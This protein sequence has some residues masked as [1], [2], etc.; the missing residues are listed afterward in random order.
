RLRCQGA[1]SHPIMAGCFWVGVLP[2]IG[3]LWWAGPAARVRALIGTTACLGI[4]LLCA[5]STPIAGVLVVALAAAV[6]P[7][8][9]HMRKIRW[10]ILLGIIGLE[11]V[12]KA[13]VYHLIARID[14]VDGSTGYHRYRLIDAAVHR[15]G[16]WAFMGTRSTAHWGWGLADVTNEYILQGVRGGALTL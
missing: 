4:I 14:L 12:M 1:F 15:F 10:A 8:R 7:F 11:I 2:W 13:P 3:A 5:S 9:A 6:F 16:E